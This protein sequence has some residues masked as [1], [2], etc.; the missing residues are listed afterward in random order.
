M[1]HKMS[2]GQLLRIESAPVSNLL[3]RESTVFMKHAL[4]SLSP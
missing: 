2:T 1:S 4:A 3:A